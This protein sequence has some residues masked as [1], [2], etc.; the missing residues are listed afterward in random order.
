MFGSKVDHLSQL[1][2]LKIVQKSTFNVKNHTNTLYQFKLTKFHVK[3]KFDVLFKK[4]PK[5]SFIHTDGGTLQA[6]KLHLCWKISTF[7]SFHKWTRETNISM[8]F[9][10]ST[11]I[12]S[13]YE[14]N[15]KEFRIKKNAG[16]ITPR[17]KIVDFGILA[18]LLE[19]LE[20][21]ISIENAI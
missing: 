16:N 13:I 3:W 10:W 7:N 21:S 15:Y 6:P 4:I 14:E 5:I 17:R 9:Y 2:H 20:N 12:R 11:K 18:C 1:L 8:V 19:C